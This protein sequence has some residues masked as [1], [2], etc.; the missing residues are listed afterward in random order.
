MS[1]KDVRRLQ[2]GMS[3]HMRNILEARGW[4][5]EAGGWRLG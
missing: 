3:F 2:Y 1:D 4:R 5:L